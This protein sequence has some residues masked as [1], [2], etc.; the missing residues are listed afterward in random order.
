M[1]QKKLSIA[2]VW[3]MHQPVYQESRNDYFLMPWVRLHAIKDYL[4]MLKVM[5]E[6]KKLKLN[7]SIVPILITALDNYG[8]KGFHD[9]HSKLTVTPIEQL[10][11]DDKFFILNN[12]FDANYANMILP[13]S[14]YTELYKKRYSFEEIGINDF[15]DEEY[16][17]ILAWFNLAWFKPELQRNHPEVNALIEKNEQFTLEDR[18]KII[19]LQREII[20][21]IIPA[22]KEY[23]ENNR[24]E[25]LANPYFH[26]VIPVL[27]DKKYTGV[28]MKEDAIEQVK[29]GIEKH[30]ETFGC[31]PKGIWPSEQCI[32]PKTL[33]LF[34]DMGF[35]WTLAD[36]GILA[37]TI[38]KE[39]VRDFK[40]YLEDPYDLTVAYEYKGKNKKPISLIFRDAV[41]PNLINFEYSQHNSVDAANDLYDRIKTIQSKLNQS[42]DKHNLLTIALD[43]ENCWESYPD[44][45]EVFIQTLYDL[46]ESDK[47][48]ETVLVSDY[49]DKVGTKK[50]LKTVHTGSWINRNLKL[51]IDEPTKDLAWNYII[52]TREDLIRFSADC[53][54]ES[55]I[56]QAWDELYIA[57]GS[58]WFWWYGEPNDSGQDEIFD[59]LFRIHLINVYNF[60]N[61]PVPEYLN[62]PLI[63]YL[64]KPLRM[65][66][67]NITPVINGVIMKQDHWKNAGCIEIPDGPILQKNKPFD[68]IYYGCD[69]DNLYLRFDMNKAYKDDSFKMAIEAMNHF[70]TFIYLKNERLAHKTSANIRTITKLETT[71]PTMMEKYTHE[72]GL[73]A[74]KGKMAP[75]VVS[76]AS[77][78]GLWGLKITNKVKMAFV[79]I[80]E[81]AI[82]FDELE[83]MPGE[84]LEFFIIHASLD[85][86]HD[87][88]P[89]DSLLSIVRPE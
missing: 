25:I 73:L 79:D 89:K 29:R 32:S 9:L 52:K 38:N 49:L 72:I 24:I 12:F 33:E 53:N 71:Y 6:Y 88:Y 59:Y 36:E 28:D 17:D 4:Y 46:I 22:Y 15:T 3:H 67:A 41:I 82:P 5:D 10:T 8:N 40:G 62:V 86:A 45:G 13:H 37:K 2:F 61:K 54:D 81:L 43:G 60:F 78:N 16:S 65:P 87:F 50:E 23:Q 20:R 30:K 75:V 11:D 57:Q 39:F 35:K 51:W 64:G 26:P 63:V 83:V 77:K 56:A 27:I 55:I 70:Q 58:D 68:K 1:A 42:P 7:F 76:K 85:I 69:K 31:V 14:R 44:D 34:A 47:T 21:K 66:R 18:V 19:E 80:L 74:I 48:L 84:R